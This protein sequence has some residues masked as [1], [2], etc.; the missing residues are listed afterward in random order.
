M[1]RIIIY[2]F[3]GLNKDYSVISSCI[4][5]LI[6]PRKADTEIKI[7][8]LVRV[9]RVNVSVV[10]REAIVT[11]RNMEGTLKVTVPQFD[12]KIKLKDL[13]SK[14]D[15]SKELRKNSD[16]ANAFRKTVCDIL[17]YLINLRRKFKF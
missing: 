3:Q 12:R 13:V 11:I 14:I 4:E 6:S 16:K 1:I 15:E 8:K 2:E 17:R 10:Q 9:Q 7:D 5:R